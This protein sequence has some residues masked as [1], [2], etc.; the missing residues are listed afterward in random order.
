MWLEL[1]QCSGELAISVLRW[2]VV[3]ALHG[4]G[5]GCLYNTLCGVS[6]ISVY[7]TC[8]YSNVNIKIDGKSQHHNFFSLYPLNQ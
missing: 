4:W 1:G 7:N 6:D 5:T 2:E 8:P 3:Q